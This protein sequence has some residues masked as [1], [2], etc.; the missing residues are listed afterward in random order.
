MGTEKR[1][2]QKEGRQARIAAAEITRRRSM[3]RRRYVTFAVIGLGVLALTAGLNALFNKND[4]SAKKVSTAASTSTTLASVKGKDCVAMKGK[5]PKGAPEVP[6][7]TGKPPAKLVVKDLKE[8]TG[9]P[10]TA[11]DTV[12]VNYIGVACTTGA[13]FGSSWAD[14]KPASFPLDQV[15]KGWTQGLPGM[16]PGGSRLL[17][18]PSELAYGTQ[19]GPPGVAPDEPLWFVVDLISAT[20]AAATTTSSVPGTLPST[21]TTTKAP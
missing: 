18:I 19:G 21:S 16:K 9:A 13:V 10:I 12:T 1:Q 17:G 15:I 8:G 11:S 5:P 7:E 14:G 2:R 3:R 20:P 6:I 4:K